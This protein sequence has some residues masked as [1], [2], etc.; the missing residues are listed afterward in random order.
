[1]EDNNSFTPASDAII[2]GTAL[3]NLNSLLTFATKAKRIIIVS[4][5]I[6]IFYNIIGLYFALQGLLAPVI[7]AILMPASTI[8]IILITFILSEWY[9]RKLPR[10]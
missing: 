9:G 4:F 8:S 3:T 5:I 6:S 7:A 10:A 1:M 2:N